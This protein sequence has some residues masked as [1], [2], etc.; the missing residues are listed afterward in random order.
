MAWPV[1]P[2]WG[3][4]AKD[5]AVDA[6]DREIFQD[7]I[8]QMSE[9]GRTLRGEIAEQGRLLRAELRTEL[10]QVHARLARIETII[11]VNIPRIQDNFETVSESRREHRRRIDDHERRLHRIEL[12]VNLRDDE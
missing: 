11:D 6:T 12:H 7:F 2:P 3:T 8:R 4:I 10:A 9:Q 1:L 5:K